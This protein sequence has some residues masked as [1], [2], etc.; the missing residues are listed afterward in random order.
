MK[1]AI[2]HRSLTKDYPTAIGG[3]GVYLITDKG[4]RI[5]DG[6]SGAAV[7]SVGHSNKEVIEAIVDQTRSLC[8][9]HTSF[10]TSEA[11]EE[12]AALIIGQSGGGTFSKIMYTSSGSEAIEA[13]LKIARQYHVFN[14]DLKRINIIGRFHSYHGNTM[15]AMAAGNNPPRREAFEPMFSPVFHHVSRCFHDKDNNGLGEKEYEDLLIAEFEAKIQ[16][17]GAETVAAVIV[18][19]VVGA[20]LGAV[21][22]TSTYLPRLKA[23]CEKN[24]IL[25]IWDEVMCGMGRSGSYHAWQSLGGVGPDLQTI[26]KGLGAGYQPLSAIL[27]NEK[28]AGMF[29]KHATASKKFINGQ[30]FQGHPVACA[31]ALAVQKII[32][33]EK[34]LVNVLARGE[35]LDASLKAGLPS[36]FFECS[37]SLRGMGLF[38]AVDF[39][40]LGAAIGGQLAQ[41]VADESF[42]QGAAVYTCSSAVD[43]VLFAPP[44]IINEQEVEILAA[45]FLKALANV[46][47]RRGKAAGIPNGSTINGSRPAV[48]VSH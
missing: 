42:K 33:R 3:D 23:L 17:L 4:Q 45:T 29:E 11:A 27:L 32:K 39:G 1:S 22:A 41:E 2:L 18:E 7:S 9:A 24:G 31:G 15:G 21:A 44:F 19:P 35:Q 38:R 25:A 47:E 30:T 10:F 26:G 16:S 48:E 28:V 13:A 6:S 14:G 40:N 46:L 36:S 34:L 43:A 8:F 37:G 20:T 12:L 5:L